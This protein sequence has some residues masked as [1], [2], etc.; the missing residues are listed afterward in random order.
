MGK[1][2]LLILFW[3][4]VAL[5]FMF[6]L[7]FGAL[8]LGSDAGKIEVHKKVNLEA[9]VKPTEAKVVLVYFGYVGCAHTCLPAM[10]ELQSFFQELEKEGLASDV[11]LYFI[12]LQRDVPEDVVDNY[13][14]SFHPQFSGFRLEPQELGVTQRE[15]KFYHSNS[16]YDT[17][18][19]SHTGYLYILDTKEEWMLSSIFI[20]KPYN[21]TKILTEIK[22]ILGG[23]R[24]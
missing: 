8:W 4:F 3:S 2:V 13:A 17:Q 7:S 20:S 5:T 11:A 12:S 23:M 16:P 24:E 14:K 15:F 18:E 1:K 21:K 9:L 22:T 10:Q 19:I 6:L